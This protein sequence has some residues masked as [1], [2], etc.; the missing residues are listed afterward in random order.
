MGD[1]YFG[2]DYQMFGRLQ[3]RGC[4]F[5][6]R[7]RDEGARGDGGTGRGRYA[8]RQAGIPGDVWGLAG[9][10]QTLSNR[11]SVRV[12]TVRKPSGTLMRLVTNYSPVQMSARDLFLTLVSAALADRMFFPVGEVPAGLPKHSLAQ[13]RPRRHHSIPTWP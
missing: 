1:R 9:Q 13:S 10:R 5:V 12:I 8:G 4:Q 3:E 11:I 6:L 7:L 2:G